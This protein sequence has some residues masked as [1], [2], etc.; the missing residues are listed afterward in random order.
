L[1]F[2]FQIERNSYFWLFLL[3]VLSFF[4]PLGY[5]PLFDLDEGAFSEATREM[6]VNKDYIT[7]YLNGELRFDKPILIYWLQALS[8]TVFGI[9]EFA[10]RLPSAL[11]SSVWMLAIF[12]FARH[13]IS[14]TVALYSGILFVTTLQISVIAKAAIA[15]GLLNMF[16]ALSMFSIYS[17]YKYNNKKFIYLT[18]AFIG[19]GALTKGPVAIMVPLVVSFLFY[20]FRKDLKSWFKAVFN[21]LGILIF[22][23]I[24]A[25]WYILEY[26]AQGQLFI[27]G[28]FLKHNLS[29]FSDAMEGHSGNYFY[30]IPVLLIGLMPHTGL[31][32]SSLT[33][34]KSYFKNDLE[35]FLFIWFAFVFFFFSFSN[36]KLPHYIIYGYTPLFIFMAMVLTRLQSDSRKSDLLIILPAIL[37]MLLFFSLPELL[38]GAEIKNSFA[39]SIKGDVLRELSWMKIPLAI[40]MAFS[41]LLFFIKSFSAQKKFLLNSLIFIIV[42]NFVLVPTV[43]RIQQQPIVDIANIVNA[44]KLKIV[45]YKLNMP[46]YNVYTQSLVEKRKPKAGEIVAL[47]KT[48]L[49]EFEKYSI[50]YEKNGIA[51]AKIE[52]VK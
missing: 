45:M 17:Y 46:S 34:V 38:A 1:G 39:R 7:T 23:L 35:L 19:L 15:D 33:K 44:Q 8:V 43:G 6:L 28:F 29:R 18:F 3:L 36:T 24:A 30:F 16:I 26:Q 4:I 50:L 10:F 13:Y 37:V 48:N 5:F 2:K 25:P 21:P 11:A 9:N 14:S 27:D 32:L 22:V 20:L 47:K 42:V 52:K 51:L 31:L 12:M 49:K 41:I 40:A